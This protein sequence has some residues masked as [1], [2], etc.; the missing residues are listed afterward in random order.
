MRVNP[1]RLHLHASLRV[2]TQRRKDGQL[3]LSSS[4]EVWLFSLLDTL[5]FVDAMF[6]VVGVC[7]CLECS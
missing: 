4:P 2:T 7:V 3:T 6:V 1:C 5:L